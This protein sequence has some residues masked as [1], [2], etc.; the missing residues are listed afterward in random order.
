[1]TSTLRERRRQMLRDEILSAADSLLSEKGYGAMSMDEIA[2]H[3]GIS[4]PTLY[5]HF[6]TKD[7]L[8]VAAAQRKIE[9]TFALV[10]AYSDEQTPLERLL[11]LLRTVIQRQ[12]EHGMSTVRPW[13]P[14]LFRLLC[15]NEGAVRSMRRLDAA[16]VDLVQQG[17]ARG[18]IAA[19]LDPPTVVRAFYAMIGSL[20]FHAFAHG[21]EP[22]PLL[23]ADT[24]ATIFERGVRPIQ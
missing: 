1:M 21:G 3:V 19:S 6:A 16:I 13:T 7:E 24:L 23:M 5:S 10:D 11:L 15:E 18:E 17:I 14:E 8:V 22:N 4:K 2:A 20:H 9:A 12:L